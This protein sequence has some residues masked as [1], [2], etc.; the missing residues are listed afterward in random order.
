MGKYP[1]WN[2]SF[3]IEIYSL[4]DEIKIKCLDE[5][6]TEDDVVGEATITV[7]DLISLSDN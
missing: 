3:D 4:D 6:L 7:N 2:Q 5:D 1:V